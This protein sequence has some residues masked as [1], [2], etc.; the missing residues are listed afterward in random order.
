MKS[1]RK[2][3]LLDHAADIR[4]EVR[5]ETLE[6][7]FLNAATALTYLLCGRKKDLKATHEKIVTIESESLDILLADWLREILFY[8][9]AENFVLSETSV[10]IEAGFLLTAKLRGHTRSPDSEMLNGIEIKG[11]TYHGLTV[12]KRTEG[13]VAQ[14]IFDA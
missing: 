4:V 3:K 6:S 9:S 1:F 13:Y 7:L 14:I 12:D 5:G 10:S 2:W 8:F 11:V